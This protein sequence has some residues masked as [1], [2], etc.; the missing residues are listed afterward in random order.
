MGSI[1]HEGLF[2]GPWFAQINAQWQRKNIIDDSPTNLLPLGYIEGYKTAA[3]MLL[4][5]LSPLDPQLDLLVFPIFFLYRQFIELLLKKVYENHH[6]SDE[7]RNMIKWCGHDIMRIFNQGED[8]IY[9]IIKEYVKYEN[10]D[11]KEI[12]EEAFDNITQKYF[13]SIKQCLGEICFYDKGSF[14]F[15]Y[16]YNRDLTETLPS[17]I[18]INLDGLK[19]F[20]ELLSTIFYGEYA[21]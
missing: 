21:I 11:N 12:S 6:T 10:R 1:I 13:N 3:D 4:E 17:P 20:A 16:N 7:Q 9:Q 2:S 19:N 18:T 8:T 14:A 15:R 5:Q